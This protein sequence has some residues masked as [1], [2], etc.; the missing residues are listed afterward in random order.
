MKFLE[1]LKQRR[2]ELKVTQEEIAKELK[3]SREQYNKWENGSYDISFKN[4]EK[5]MEYLTRKE[6]DNE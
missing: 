2:K 6:N 5:A 3:C 1:V 4:Y